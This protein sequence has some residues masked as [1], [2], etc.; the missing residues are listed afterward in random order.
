MQRCV[1]SFRYGCCRPIAASILP[2]AL[3]ENGAARRGDRRDATAHR[4]ITMKASLLQCTP[5]K[6]N[7]ASAAHEHQVL[8]YNVH[9]ELIISLLSVDA[10][11]TSSSPAFVGLEVRMEATSWTVGWP[12][13]RSA[14]L[15]VCLS[16]CLCFPLFFDNHRR[17][18]RR[19][20]RRRER[21]RCFNRSIRFVRS[22]V[23]GLRSS[24]IHSPLHREDRIAKRAG[25]PRLTASLQATSARRNVAAYRAAAG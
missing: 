13:G 20:R 11:S 8:L 6:R 25:L 7:S 24:V 3:S 14:D 21:H 22:T 12:V 23:S 2:T 9:W 18:R 10:S 19:R 15:S 17:R 1:C 4:K 16:V 5:E